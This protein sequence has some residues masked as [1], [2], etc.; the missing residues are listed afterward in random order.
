[1][2][3]ARYIILITLP[4]THLSLEDEC[5]QRRFHSLVLRRS[6]RSLARKSALC[7]RSWAPAI[8]MDAGTP[9]RARAVA[10]EQVRCATGTLLLALTVTVATARRHGYHR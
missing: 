7:S 5:M 4:V 2:P 10:G 1:M 9:D 8:Q 6:L 3:D